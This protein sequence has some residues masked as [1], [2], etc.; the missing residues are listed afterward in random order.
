MSCG[1]FCVPVGAAGSG[2]GGDPATAVN[3]GGFTEVYVA[4][5]SNP[6][7][8]RT[9]QSSDS[10]VNIAQNAQDID[11]TVTIPP[12][13]TAQ[14]VGGFAEAYVAG[15]SDPFDFRTFQSSDS[16][17]NITQNA[18][19]IDLT[20]TPATVANVGG[21]AEVYVAGSSNPF[22]LRTIQSSDSSIT[23]VQNADNIDLRAVGGGAFTFK[24][25]DDTS[26]VIATNNT[27][28][29]STVWISANSNMTA[30]E[31]WYLWVNCLICHPSG[32]STVNTQIAW[33]IETGAGI[34]SQLEGDINTNQPQT[35][36]PGQRS[37]P[38]GRFYRLL[39]V[40]R[41]ACR[42]MLQMR[43]SAAVATGGQVEY[44]RYLALRVP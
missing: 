26:N 15:S 4:G 41:T 35:I 10:S 43:M 42:V 22:N 33:F 12:A 21:F 44:P 39:P 29:Y 5:S 14:N 1:S 6:F 19:D 7:E 18:Q 24:R 17:V 8:F 13:A 20:V 25:S 27:N 37:A 34:F 11:L 23:V 2:S 38:Y 9:L 3:V 31:N 40:A 32:L 36:P 16:S 30:G 28:V